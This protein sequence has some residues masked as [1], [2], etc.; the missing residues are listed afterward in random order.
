M[1]KRALG[2]L[3]VDVAGTQLTAADR[4][5][6]AHPGIGGVILFARNYADPEQLRALVD[7]IHGIRQ[8]RLLVAVDQEGGRVQRF[9]DGFTRL[10]AMARL[11]N[12]YDH[13]PAAAEQGAEQIGWL[14]AAELRA[15]GVDFSFAPVLDLGCGVSSVIGD[16]A[17]HADPAKVAVLAEALI[18][19]MAAAGMAAVGK[20]FPGHGSVG[21]D[22]HYEIP[23][24]DR[25][26][27]T[28][29]QRD[30]LPFA[31]LA[32][33]G[34][35]A[36]MPAHV[37]YPAVA[38]QAAGLSPTW[39]T[40]ILR[41][42][43]GFEGAIFSDDLSMAAVAKDAPAARVDAALKAG[44]DMALLCNDRPAVEAALD[45]CRAGTATRARARLLCMQGAAAPL[46]WAERAASSRWQ[47]ARKLSEE[48]AASD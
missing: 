6:L 13:D 32:A 39:L 28:I 40:T 41:G 25:D 18:R 11:G 20:H 24:D 12:W 2:P 30:G 36:I 34:L 22:S 17:L 38:P 16:R 8:P 44:C 43:F 15:V 5:L 23:V 10:P 48:M 19:G 21:P 45:A 42:E 29:R 35:S 37:V 46:A 33:R 27:A 9:R 1:T 47:Q 31:R 14:L 26:A 7:Q 4:D 3:M